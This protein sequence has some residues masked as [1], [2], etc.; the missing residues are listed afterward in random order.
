[1]SGHGVSFEIT[2]RNADNTEQKWT[3]TCAC[4][5][6]WSDATYEAAEDQ[7]R[8]HVHKVTGR[9]PTPAGNKSG[10]WTP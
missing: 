2:W 9:A 7:W 5:M 3:A 10:R 4:R 8:R 1:V 6:A